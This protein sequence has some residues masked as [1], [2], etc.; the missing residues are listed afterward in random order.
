[1]DRR[2]GN[3]NLPARRKIMVVCVLSAIFVITLLTEPQSLFSQIPD[4]TSE[5]KNMPG[6]VDMGGGILSLPPG[7]AEKMNLP[8]MKGPG[9]VTGTVT[10]KGYGQLR[11]NNVI[12][13][14]PAAI[15]PP[16]DSPE[17]QQMFV[18]L[19]EQ[20]AKNPDED[21]IIVELTTQR[22]GKLATNLTAN[23]NTILLPND[24]PV[25]NSLLVLLKMDDLPEIRMDSIKVIPPV[26]IHKEDPVYPETAKASGISGDVF[27]KV[28]TDEKG[29]TTTVLLVDGNP[30][31]AKAAIAAI[32]QWR[33][34]PARTPNEM[35]RPIPATFV[36]VIHFLPDGTVDLDVE[37]AFFAGM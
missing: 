18:K 21:E 17:L 27:L 5:L 8:E 11:V 30:D 32:S 19:K 7:L 20:Y 34:E 10:L 22:D 35:Q 14:D 26:P 36:V 33:Y 9:R 29:D 15:K 31:L 1:M 16:I 28:S 23:G 6:V 3:F 2:Q 24:N 13:P 25:V 4:R 37:D 12:V